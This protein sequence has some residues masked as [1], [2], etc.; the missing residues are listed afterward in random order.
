GTPGYSYQLNNSF[1]ST[2]N[3]LVAS[4]GGQM[5]VSV[6]DSNL[7]M[8]TDT[9]FVLE[10]SLLQ[11]DVLGVKN[12]FCENDQ[13]GAV[14]LDGIG[15]VGGYQFGLTP[16]NIASTDSIKGLGNGSYTIYVVD[17]NN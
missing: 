15:G 5:L 14:G 4:K 9:V 17:A 8:A 6:L 2:N 12:E 1:P 13:S 16:Q 11:L 3:T 7:C 10:P